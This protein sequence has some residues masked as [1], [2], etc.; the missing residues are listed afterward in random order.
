MKIIR[1]RTNH[2][3]NPLGFWFEQPVISWAVTET[4]DKRQEA[5]DL[6]RIEEKLK[7]I[8]VRRDMKNVASMTF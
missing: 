6:E 4:G 5:A 8:P 7:M 1:C 2:M 3:K